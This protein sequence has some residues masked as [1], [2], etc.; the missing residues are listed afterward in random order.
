M[1][2]P[3]TGLLLLSLVRVLIEVA[4]FALLGQGMLALLA[5][6][7]RTANPVYRL[8]AVVAAPVLRLLRMMAPRFI[9]DRHLPFLAFFLLF[10]LWLGLAFAK[11]YIC[12]VNGLHCFN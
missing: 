5:G 6:K 7:G 8:F 11:R 4:L 3:A 1:I 10:W 9:L 12:A 2:A